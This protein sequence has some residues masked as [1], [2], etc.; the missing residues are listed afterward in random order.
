MKCGTHEALSEEVVPCHFTL[1]V[2]AVFAGGNAVRRDEGGL[3]SLADAALPAE[4]L[5][6]PADVFILLPVKLV[7]GLAELT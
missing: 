6:S 3:N 4:D 5:D 7:W 1:N 2:A